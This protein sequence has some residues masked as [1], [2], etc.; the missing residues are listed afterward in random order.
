MLK[1]KRFFYTPRVSMDECAR[2]ESQS[3]L[4]RVIGRAPVTALVH[5]VEGA[6]LS[7][8]DIKELRRILREKEKSS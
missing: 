5:L 6:D 2:Q 1:G 7:K 3:F 4:D 8:E